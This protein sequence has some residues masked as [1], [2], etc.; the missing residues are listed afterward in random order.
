MFERIPSENHAGL[1]SS[2]L[3]DYSFNNYPNILS[4]KYPPR[5]HKKKWGFLAGAH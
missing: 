1:L 2:D 5:A 3:I 4:K